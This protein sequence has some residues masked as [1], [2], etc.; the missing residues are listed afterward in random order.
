MSDVCHSPSLGEY[1]VTSCESLANILVHSYLSTG[2]CKGQGNLVRSYIHI[3]TSP[4]SI[5]RGESLKHDYGEYL[6]YV[7]GRVPQV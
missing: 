5:I 2:A 4:L 6:K 3:L 1:C 7:L